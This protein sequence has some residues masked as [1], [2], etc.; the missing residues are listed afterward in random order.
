MAEKT[1]TNGHL[2]YNILPLVLSIG[3][4]LIG[5]T[6]FIVRPDAEMHEDI[7]LIKQSV[8][9]IETNH[10][11]HL[12]EDIQN[13]TDALKEHDD[14]IDEV[15]KKLDRILYLLGDKTLE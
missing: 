1:Y 4:M 5:V 7:A 14:E 8:K 9:T 13:N 10:L 2:I 15:C 3:A 6:L 11:V 12:K